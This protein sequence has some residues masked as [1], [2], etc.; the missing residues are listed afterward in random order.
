[1]RAPYPEDEEDLRQQIDNLIG[2]WKAHVND[3]LFVE[4]GFYPYY[5]HQPVKVLFMGRESRGLMNF[6]YIDVLFRA[7][8]SNRIGKQTLAGN[9]FHRRLLYLLYGI[10]N[11]FPEWNEVPS[12][13]QIAKKFGTAGGVSCAFMNLSKSSNESNHFA[14][15]WDN[16]H[17]SVNKGQNFILEEIAL[18]APDIIIANRINIEKHL[19]AQTKKINTLSDDMVNVWECT[20]NAKTIPC[21]NTF[22]FSAISRG[23]GKGFSDYYSYYLPIKKAYQSLSSSIK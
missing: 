7:Y 5:T 8:K 15:R 17:Q 9:S 19:P 21:L 20:L 13:Q 10:L 11:Q 16:Y 1:M 3:E 14:T 23:K 2:R 12:I 6:N 22:H 4:D 18:L